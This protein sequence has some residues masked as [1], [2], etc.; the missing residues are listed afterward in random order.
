[1]DDPA[2]LFILT[3]I[4][5]I[6]LHLGY[7]FAHSF[8]DAT[9][10][11]LYS[12]DTD[13]AYSEVFQY[14]KEYWSALL[15]AFLTARHRSILDFVWSLLFFYL[16]LDDAIQIHESLGALIST[17]LGFPGILNLRPVD[18]G[19]FLVSS[20]VGLLF[21]SSIVLSIR[22]GDRISRKA[23]KTL[24]LL[25]LLLAVFGVAVDMLHIIIRK[26][27]TN[28]FIDEGLVGALE[29]GGEMVVMSAIASFIFEVAHQAT[30]FKSKEMSL[31]TT[32][33]RT[34]V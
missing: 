27:V 19:E 7:Y 5:F 13:R 22:F 31:E 29:D 6:L 8:T 4:I 33:D 14:I 17:K 28:L 32:Y 25:L 3:D 21:L 24:I 18:L 9:P 16:F 1:M 11:Y 20:L 26:F 34:R 12:L 15:L 10:S 30:S 2:I 23:S